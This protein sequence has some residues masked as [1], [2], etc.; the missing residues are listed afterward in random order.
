MLAQESAVAARAAAAGGDEL[1]GA[2]AGGLPGHG[3]GAAPAQGSAAVPGA[4]VL[5]LRRRLR[6]RHHRHALRRLGDRLGLPPQE[7]RSAGH[8]HPRQRRRGGGEPRGDARAGAAGCG[9]AQ[10]A[11]GRAAPRAAAA[12]LRA[13]WPLLDLLRPPQGVGAAA[14]G[15]GLRLQHGAHAG[16]LA[17]ALRQPH[18]PRQGVGLLRALRGD[19]QGLVL[20]GSAGPRRRLPGASPCA[21]V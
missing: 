11:H 1:R 10:D 5:L 7:P 12:L 19:G 15:G 20:H 3:H 21:H 6:R 17:H 4:L 8:D 14:A 18:P 13:H 2:V 9:R 16:L